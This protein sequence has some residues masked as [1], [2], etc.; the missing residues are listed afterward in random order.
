VVLAC[1]AALAQAQ[2][3]P[4]KY[5]EYLDAAANVD[6][7]SGTVLI[8]RR[9]RV[10]LEQSYGLADRKANQP[11][12]NDTMYRI[13]SMSKPITATAVMVLRDQG[14]LKLE[15]SICLYLSPC[16]DAWKAIKL[17]NLLTHTSGIPDVV[18]FPDYME[19]RVKPHTPQQM[20]D[21]IASRPV[22]FASGAK[23]VYCNSN[24]I[25]LG[26]VI[27]KASGMR[28]E[29]YLAKNVLAPAG[30]KHTG[31]EANLAG[32]MAN[33]YVRDGDNYRDPDPSD[34]SVRFS[35]GGLFSTA[36]DLL[37]LTRALQ[38][39]TVLKQSTVTEMWTDRGNGYGYGW[40]PD[41]EKGHKSIGHNGRIDGFAS[42]FRLFQDDDLFIAIL[43]NVNGTNTERMIGVLAAISHGEPFRMPKVRTFI[44]VPAATLAQYEGRYKLP[45]G[46]V[47]VVTHEGDQLFG[48]A[49]Q[50]KKPT[51]W[52][53]ES[54][55]KF[56]V[57]PADIEIDFEKDASGKMVLNFDGG[58]KAEKID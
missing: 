24:F 43:S 55:T 34:M 39:G 46:L 42:S 47:L 37:A 29:K 6:K 32:R 56:Y 9:G 33:G 22:D 50:E 16:P 27:E 23:F 31:Y 49:E 19:F 28:Y 38:A 45:W 3:S 41:D 35:A 8:A 54:T 2:D 44:S 53:A 30:M 18:K 5:R 4:A 51:E 57:P 58:A 17:T 52:K 1:I 13:G 15:D 20:M 11:N 7:F 48:R 14:K 21:L 40:I 26:V 10:I 12:T 36:D 25:L